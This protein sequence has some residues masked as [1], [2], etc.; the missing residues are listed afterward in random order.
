ME[1]REYRYEKEE[2]ILTL[3]ESVGWTNYTRRPE[4]LRAAWAGSLLILGAWEGARLVGVI[5]CVG[6]GAS[7]LY[8][9]DLLVNPAHQRQGIGSAL[10]RAAVARYP[11]VYQT[12]LMTDAT[13]E[14]LAFYR[15][16]GFT[17]D[18]ELGCCGFLR[19]TAG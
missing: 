14:H 18:E 9:Q 3:Y 17:L 7:I 13:P 16:C 4:M 1:L 12:V 19:M 2:E 6:D 8:I 11:S 5:R 15:A 10:L